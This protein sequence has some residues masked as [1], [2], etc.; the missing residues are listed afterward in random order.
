MIRT[1]A[2]QTSTRECKTNLDMGICAEN[3]I[4][5]A[6]AESDS[7]DQA[8]RIRKKKENIEKETV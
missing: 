7:A 5:H 6:D 8:L 2:Y 1:R 4:M 3:E